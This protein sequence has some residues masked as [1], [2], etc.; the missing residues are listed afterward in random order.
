MTVILR[1]DCWLSTTTHWFRG[2][3]S[4]RSTGLSK[5]RHTKSLGRAKPTIKPTNRNLRKLWTS[6]FDSRS[7]ANRTVLFTSKMSD[8]KSALRVLQDILD[9]IRR[10]WPC[11]RFVNTHVR[12]VIVSDGS[13]GFTVNFMHVITLFASVWSRTNSATPYPSSGLLYRI[14]K[15]GTHVACLRS[16]LCD[17]RQGRI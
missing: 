10:F 7:S 6:N 8:P 13:F 16:S 15:F 17:S 4:V 3:G 12:F 2:H 14:T 5:P 11:M 9:F 1:K